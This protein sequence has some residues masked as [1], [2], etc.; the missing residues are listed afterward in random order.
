MHVLQFSGGGH[1]LVPQLTEH[2]EKGESS[3]FSIPPRLSGS[4]FVNKVLNFTVFC[5]CVLLLS[6]QRGSALRIMPYLN[7]VK[8]I[9]LHAHWA[10]TISPTQMHHQVRK[11]RTHILNL[12]INSSAENN[13]VMAMEVYDLHIVQIREYPQ[14]QTSHPLD[15]TP[16][17]YYAMHFTY[18]PS[19]AYTP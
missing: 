2:N 12:C 10:F 9:D 17:E 13:H 5:F 14:R 1:C 19:V 3:D 11:Q 8:T 18:I 7:C 4:N 15:Q 16:R 6:L